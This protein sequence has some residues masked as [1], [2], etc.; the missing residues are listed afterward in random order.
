MVGVGAPAIAGLALG[1]ADHIDL[2]VLGEQLERP[3][4]GGEP[5]RVAS[6]AHHGVDLLADRNSSN[7][8]RTSATAWRCRVRRSGCSTTGHLPAAQP[9]PYRPGEREA[10]QRQQHDASAPGATLASKSRERYA[11][12][13]SPPNEAP[14]AEHHRRRH[15]GAERARQLL[16]GRDRHHHQRRDEQQPDRA[17]RHRDG[18]RREHGDEQVVGPDPHAGDPRELRVLGDREE[19]GSRPRHTTITTT[20]A[21]G[22]RRPPARRW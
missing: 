4:D 19:L 3:V 14:E 22:E 20:G 15:R 2:V 8:S 21:H 7:D 11:A 1:D 6:L 18:H 16:C 17:H 5:D 9:R 13:S 12:N 10:G